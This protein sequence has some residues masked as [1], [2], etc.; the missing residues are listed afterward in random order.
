MVSLHLYQQYLLAT[1]PREIPEEIEEIDEIAEELP[2][3]RFANVIDEDKNVS[4]TE[5]NLIVLE[6]S[7]LNE[8]V[9]ITSE[10][11]IETG[12]TIDFEEKH[13]KNY[14]QTLTSSEVLIGVS[15]SLVIIALFIYFLFRFSN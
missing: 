14:I 9:A 11:K 2:E 3:M 1:Y 4:S 7:K 6:E 12:A 15:A 13:E 5:E 10:D 8:D